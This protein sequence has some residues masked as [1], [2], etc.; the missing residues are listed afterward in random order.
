MVLHGLVEFFPAQPEP[1]KI[2]REIVGSAPQTRPVVDADIF[3]KSFGFFESHN[4]RLQVVVFAND[5]V[6]NP[7]PQLGEDIYIHLT[8]DNSLK[9]FTVASGAFDDHLMPF[10]NPSG[11]LDS[12]AGIIWLP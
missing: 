12:I 10:F 9:R 7:V 5:S 6:V 1:V 2:L 8:G 3:K 11:M 4:T